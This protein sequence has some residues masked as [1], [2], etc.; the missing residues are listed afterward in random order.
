MALTGIIVQQVWRSAYLPT[1]NNI[2]IVCLHWQKANKKLN[3]IKFDL[4]STELSL[5]T[6]SRYI[7]VSTS[8]LLQIQSHQ[9]GLMGYQGSGIIICGHSAAVACI[10]SNWVFGVET[11]FVPWNCHFI[12]FQAWPLVA[13]SGRGNHTDLRASAE[14][15]GDGGLVCSRL[16]NGTL[17]RDYLVYQMRAF[18]WWQAV[19]SKPEVQSQKL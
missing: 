18:N 14:G 5:M 1:H 13:L 19:S 16:V 9:P 8:E 15:G 11:Q 10:R 2:R 17:F 4:E 7:W 3:W 6:L 12:R